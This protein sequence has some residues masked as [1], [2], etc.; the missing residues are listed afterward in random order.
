M[1]KRMFVILVVAL[2]L[3][4]A[5]PVAAAECRHA[6]LKAECNENVAYGVSVGAHNAQYF[7]CEK[8]KIYCVTDYRCFLCGIIPHTTS[9]TH[10]CY[11]AHDCSLPREWHCL[12]RNIGQY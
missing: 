6:Y 3:V 7:L 11:T 5:F 8:I 4:T 9:A 2:M 1:K 12:Y 10:A